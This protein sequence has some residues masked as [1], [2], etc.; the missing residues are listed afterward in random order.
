MPKLKKPVKII[1][2]I[3]GILLVLLIAA[4]LILPKPLAMSVYNDN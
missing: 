1:L 4:A 3:L 2:I